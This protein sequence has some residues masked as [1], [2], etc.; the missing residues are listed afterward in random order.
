[1]NF[2]ELGLK[3]T[4][5]ESIEAMGFKTPS[6][7]QEQAIPLVL[8]KKD[9]IAQAHTGTGKTAAFGLPALNMI[10][11]ER[12]VQVLI[13]APT[14][15]LANQ[16]SDELFAFGKNDGIRTVTVLG[17]QGYRHQIQRIREG[18][19]VVVATPGRLLD[20][21]KGGKVGEFNP[22]IVI[23]DEADE[24]LDM[25]FSD[26]IHEIFSFLPK[27]RQ[28]LLFS[29]TMSDRIQSLSKNILTD[30]VSVSVVDEN[31]ETVNKN[32]KE[33]YCVVEERE[34]DDAVFRVLEAQELDKVV[35]FCR[36]KS[37][38]DRLTTLMMGRGFLAKALHGDM[39]QRQREAVTSSFKKG[40]INVLVATD[41]AA[42]GLDVKGVSHVIN[43]HIPFGPDS[44]V[45]RIGRTGRAGEKGVAIT[46]VSPRECRELRRIKTVVG[47]E[48]EFFKL[49]S[50][51]ELKLDKF[52]KF[53]D[54]LQ[55]Q[56]ISGAAHDFLKQLVEQSD[57]QEI[58]LKLLSYNLEVEAVEGPDSI[59]VDGDKLQRF[60]ADFSGSGSRRSGGRSRSRGGDRGFGGRRR[61]RSRFKSDSAGSG[62]GS[63]EGR[64]RG[65]R[66]SSGG[67]GEF[68]GRR[69]N[70]KRKGNDNSAR[71]RYRD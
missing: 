34:R 13:M 4:L 54:N 30:P 3:K 40:E 37:E 6:P 11:S 10:S 14:R 26:D 68:G 20:L 43:F 12:K 24:M 65:R 47:S 51:N 33:L 42:R 57:L 25:G 31:A 7:I 21:L 18:A 27:K 71:G 56:Q 67:E 15:E 45:H 53:M 58:A 61:G 52:Q 64:G 5:L 55:N 63:S 36:T 39:E 9:L 46:L 32:I 29:A 2:S 1:M 50:V 60:M 41:V 59:G 44:Y 69:R 62:S 28:T 38:V 49:P 19:Q 23:L 17:G 66:R 16:V 48:M 35:I 8:S 70:R 22:E